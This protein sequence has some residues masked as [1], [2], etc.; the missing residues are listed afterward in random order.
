[1]TSLRSDIR[2]SFR[3][4]GAAFMDP[5]SGLL[6]SLNAT[7]SLI[8]QGLRDGQSVAATA[9]LLVNQFGITREKALASVEN[10]V[11]QCRTAGLLTE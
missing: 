10:F 3:P 4:D 6:Y 8:A 7:A 11:A 2:S 1:M 5:R 9:D